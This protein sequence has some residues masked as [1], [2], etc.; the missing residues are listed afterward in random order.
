MK[1]LFKSL[2]V[3]AVVGVLAAGATYALFTD[4]ETSTANTITAGTLDLQL[5]CPAVPTTTADPLHPDQGK[6]TTGYG[7]YNFTPANYTALSASDDNRY[8]SQYGWFNSYLEGTDSEPYEFLD[9][10]VLGVPSDATINSANLT[11]EW[12][13][14]TGVDG[15]R[16]KI[17]NGS[18][19]QTITPFAT[20]PTAYTDETKVINLMTYGIDTPA[21]IAALRIQFQA[22]QSGGYNQYD[23]ASRTWIDLVEVNVNYTQP[24]SVSW[25]ASN[26]GPQFNVTN[27]KPTDS[28]ASPAVITFRNNGTV[29]GTL[30]IGVSN[31][32][33][34][35]NT[36]SAVETLAGDTT[37]TPGEMSQ[38]L[39]LYASAIDGT[40]AN[41]D[42]GTIA[43]LVATPYN[44]GTI[45]G[46]GNHTIELNW[47]LPDNATVNQV[48]SDGSIF[49]IDFILEQ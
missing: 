33:D 44:V 38:Y 3:L 13:R 29:G 25:C 39:H 15:A 14:G 30:K 48:Q 9:F 18:T 31:I 34:N 49:N 43:S 8:Q 46:S 20:L 4:T 2:G 27:V 41:I 40:P 21:E 12:Q 6:D 47:N 7:T 37:D 28:G 26:L 32:V 1:T 24:G 36:R 45:T 11:F 23:N 17:Y 16:M 5:Q 22:K 42:L 19:W 35:E 10:G